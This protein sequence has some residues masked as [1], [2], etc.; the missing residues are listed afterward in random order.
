MKKKPYR[1]VRGPEGLLPPAAAS[2]GIVLPEKGEGLVEGCIVTEQDTLE[3][4]A[5]QLLTGKNPTI[6]PGPLVL[7]AWRDGVAE[8]AA[9]V[10]E[11]ADEIPGVRIIPMPDYRPIY[12]KIDPEA[13]INPC[14]PN[15][16]IWHNKI[17]VCVFVGVHCHF[18]NITL[19]MIRAGTNCYTITLCHEAGHEDSMA[20]LPF[21]GVDQV[22]ALTETIRRLK[23]EGLRPRYAE[24]PGVQLTATQQAVLNGLVWQ[25]GATS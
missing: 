2:R 16:T 6:F 14:H 21:C 18:A 17:E 25:Q 7:W 19:K 1:V 24:A 15:L 12:P 4:M 20:S 10:L 11:L 3:V 5:R 9:A 8:K 23:S 13:V 22:R